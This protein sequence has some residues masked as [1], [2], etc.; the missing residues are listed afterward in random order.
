MTN[1]NNSKGGKRLSF[2]KVFTQEE[3]HIEVPIIQ[4][5]YAQGRPSFDENRPLFL[6]AL[7]TYL[8]ENKPNR[9]L[10]FVYGTVEK[11]DKKNLFIPLDGQQRLTTLFLLHWYLALKED[12]LDEF[13]SVLQS[14][15]KSK[16]RYKTRTSSTDFF[17]ALLKKDNSIDLNDLK[18]K[19]TK[20]NIIYKSIKDIILDSGWFFSNWKNDPTVKSILRMINAI[21]D[22]FKDSEPFFERLT[23]EDKPIITF[24]FLNI[25]DYGLTDDLYIKMNA[26]GKELTPFENFKAKLEQHIKIL[27]ENSDKEY[28]KD[29]E[30]QKRT[31]SVPEY[32]SH[33]IDT[34][35]TNLFWQ[36]RNDKGEIDDKI[37]NFIQTLFVNHL[38]K[39]D[40]QLKIGKI[41]DKKNVSFYDYF[42]TDYLN[43]VFIIEVIEL[44]DILKSSN[45]KAKKFLPND[46]FYYDEV[47]NLDY[48][49]NYN[50][51]NIN[52][53]V[54]FHA[55]CQYLIKNKTSEGLEDWM[56]LIHN[57]TKN[58]TYDGLNELVR[59]I[60]AVQKLLNHS[61]YI[62]T[63]L[64]TTGEKIEDGFVEKQRYEEKIKALLL[65][66]DN[67]RERILQV[68]QH[69][70]F[71][72]Q[73]GFLL[74]FS[75]IEDYYNEYDNCEWNEEKD[76]LFI[77]SFDNYYNKSLSIFDY[78]ETGLRSFKNYAWHRALLCKGDYLLS[79]SSNWSFLI[80]NERD[81]SWKRLLFADGDNRR[82]RRKFIKELFDGEEFDI[83]NPK[84]YFDAIIEKE[85]NIGDWREGFIQF[86]KLLSYLGGKKYI[87]WEGE[88]NI[89]LLRKERTSGE[90]SEYYSHWFYYKHIKSQDFTPF[91][92]VDY[93]TKTGREQVTPCAFID[94]FFTNSNKN[95]YAIDISFEKKQYH[96]KFFNRHKDE[97]GNYTIEKEIYD[98]LIRLK[99]YNFEEKVIHAGIPKQITKV[100]TQE[101]A[102]NCIKI[103]CS[104]LKT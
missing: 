60:K 54:Q 27:F 94:H 77:E 29:Y 92:K 24:M 88:Y 22:T 104:T 102:I 26:R 62:L 103:I 39:I 10:D 99:E 67:W 7:R 4:R 48:S 65:R 86:P 34:D 17:D 91:K 93:F 71:T 83:F 6:N 46:F 25:G 89:R 28:V 12:K 55:Y 44:L 74:N 31:M 73:I 52:S 57:L 13:R 95:H 43:E 72:G 100:D 5:D 36:Y 30:G 49:L 33:Q 37:M 69:G 59:D 9:D 76:V 32:F 2:H 53:R 20:G 97:N 61:N 84:I 21:H 66:K 38:A 64:S 70:Y 90:Y 96:I 68:E 58:I 51:P 40:N 14:E 35:W 78:N 23:D 11:L 98:K 47:K 19:D 8:E 85:G 56:R 87:R 82:S 50:F 81:I 42:E 15:K 75:G 45:E 41:V 80:D 3:L 79:Q 101:E 16:F 18:L 63:H 1:I